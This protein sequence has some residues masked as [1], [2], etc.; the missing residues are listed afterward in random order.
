M[1]QARRL[2]DSGLHRIESVEAGVPD[3]VRAVTNGAA[4]KIGL[5][6]GA[7]LHARNRPGKKKLDVACFGSGGGLIWRRKW[8]PIRLRNYL[9][10][11]TDG[12]CEAR[13]GP[14]S[15]VWPL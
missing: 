8:T 12:S 15:E 1:G 5:T 6:Y 2:K 3:Y 14:A 11:T 10:D 9:R 7:W 4:I 13:R